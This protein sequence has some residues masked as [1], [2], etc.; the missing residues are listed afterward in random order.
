MAARKQQPKRRGPR[1]DGYTTLEPGRAKPWRAHYAGTDQYFATKSEGDVWRAERKAAAQAARQGLVLQAPPDRQTVE[2]AVDDFL[3]D[4]DWIAPGTARASLVHA[5]WITQ[6]LGDQAIGDVTDEDIKRLVTAMRDGTNERKRKYVDQYINNVLAL[7]NHLFSRLVA[8]RRITW[9]PV[10]A[11]RTLYPRHRRSATPHRE[12]LPVDPAIAR[13]I[14]AAAEPAYQSAIATLFVLGLRIGELRGLRAVNVDAARGVVRIVEQ[15]RGTARHEAAPLKTERE[16]G[17][18]RTLP[19][20]PA[21]L[22]WLTIPDDGL[23]FPAADGGALAE[24]TFRKHFYRA[25]DKAGAPPMRVHDTRHTAATG[26]LLVGA[27]KEIRAA[28]LGHRRR[29]TTDHYTQIGPDVLRPYLEHWAALVLPRAT[30]AAR[31]G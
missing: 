12:P 30:A 5:A 17:K 2:A 26:I 13:R 18:G 3:A 28:F 29:E 31:E 8:K 9:N 14:I 19:L 25:R 20:P 22:D 21:L 10:A 23:L 16:I 11:Y 15:R 6:Y 27:T 7:A 24:N 4:R 1:G